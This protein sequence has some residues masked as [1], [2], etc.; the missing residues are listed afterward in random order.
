MDFDEANAMKSLARKLLHD[1]VLNAFYVHCSAHCNELFVKDVMKQSP[2][3]STSR[4]LCQA[5]CDGIVEIQKYFKHENNSDE[6]KLLTLQ[7]LFATRWTTRA[8]AANVIF[9]KNAELRTTLEKLNKD[10]NISAESKTRIRRILKRQMSSLHVPFKLNM[11]RKLVVLFG[12]YSKELTESTV[13]L[14]MLCILCGLL[15][16]G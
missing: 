14:I 13:P 10:P 16:R 2:L 6:Y 7:S 3:L 8:K 11:T 1:V 12:K 5:I 15:H 9:D 4:D